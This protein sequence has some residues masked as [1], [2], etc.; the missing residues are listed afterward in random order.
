MTN[1]GLRQIVEDVAKGFD[2][3]VIEQA[4]AA[5]VSVPRSDDP[6]AYAVQI[7]QAVGHAL[8]AA[9]AVRRAAPG[10][11]LVIDAATQEAMERFALAYRDGR[12]MSEPARIQ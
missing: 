5:A 10:P 7:G 4:V 12:L 8:E 6:R 3:A 9:L 11:P 2:A 1:E